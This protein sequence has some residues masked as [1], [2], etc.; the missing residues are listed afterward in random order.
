MEEI[1]LQEVLSS[2]FTY[3]SSKMYT[4]IPCVV[5]KVHNSLNECKVDVQPSVNSLYK[6][7]KIEEHPPIL[8]VPVIFPSSKTSSFTF[9]I[10]VGD[11]V[12]CVFASKSID[13]FK[14]GTGGPTIPNDYRKFDKRDAIAIPGLFP[15][16]S[17]INNPS[18]HTW[19]HNTQD[20]VVAHNLGTGNEVEI[21]LK[22]NGD[23]VVN[24]NQNIA[25]NCTNAVVNATAVDVN[26]S[27]MTVDVAATTWNGNITQ[28]GNFTLG[29]VVLNTHKHT[30]VQAGPSQTGGPV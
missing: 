19:P 11:T 14:R 18:K 30:G 17:S 26:A 9:P 28:T 25:V 12:L 3:Q 2:A 16:G 22:A 6:S 1:S 5:L 24:T 29:G 21:R 15:F 13:N 20:A 27:S 10:N 4:S 23:M 7:G 8:S